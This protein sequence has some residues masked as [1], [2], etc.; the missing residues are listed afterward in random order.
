MFT[1][2]KVSAIMPV[3]MTHSNDM[4]VLA[5]STLGSATEIESFL[6]FIAP[7]RWPMQVQ[8]SL[9]RVTVVDSYADNLC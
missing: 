4:L 3:T 6:F 5:L 9:S 7:L 8:L 1:L 2:A